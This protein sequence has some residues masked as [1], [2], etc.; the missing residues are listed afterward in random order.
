MRPSMDEALGFICVC[1]HTQRLRQA[2]RQA[3]RQADR[4]TDRQTDRQ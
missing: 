2:G 4:Q 1:A 3:G